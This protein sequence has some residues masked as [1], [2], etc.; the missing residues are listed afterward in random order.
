MIRLVFVGKTS[1][2]LLFTP[3]VLQVIIA[4]CKL[5]CL[6]PAGWWRACEWW[7]TKFATLP[8]IVGVLYIVPTCLN[9]IVYFSIILRHQ[10]VTC[11]VSLGTVD[12][13]IHKLFSTRADL[14]RTVYTHA[15]VKVWMI[16]L[17]YLLFFTTLCFIYYEIKKHVYII[18]QHQG[19]KLWI[20]P[21]WIQVRSWLV[22]DWFKAFLSIPT[23]RP[24]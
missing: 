10:N 1:Y 23:V 19:K 17:R 9:L 16:I 2:W 13:S 12:L 14:H 7:V 24:I 22:H 18:L 20:S 4:S 15:K 3:F 5:Y 8:K 6:F 21:A 11:H